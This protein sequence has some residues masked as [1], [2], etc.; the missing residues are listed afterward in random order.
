MYGILTIPPLSCVGDIYHFI[1]YVQK[2]SVIII[3]AKKRKS[4]NDDLNQLT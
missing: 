2:C 1:V 3:K 4:S